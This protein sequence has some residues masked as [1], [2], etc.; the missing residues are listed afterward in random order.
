MCSFQLLQ[1][2]SVLPPPKWFVSISYITLGLTITLKNY[3]TGVALAYAVYSP[4]YSA[5]SSYVRGTI[6]DNSTFLRVGAV[7][8]LVRAP[9]HPIR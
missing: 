6:R 5:T 9:S 7:I 2:L 1:Q 3:I 8:W 4:T